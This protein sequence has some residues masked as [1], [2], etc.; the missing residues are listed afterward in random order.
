MKNKILIGWLASLLLLFSCDEKNPEVVPIF[1]TSQLEAPPLSYT[2]FNAEIDEVQENQIIDLIEDHGFVWSTSP[3]NSLD[4]P[5]S[6]IIRIGVKKPNYAFSS[7]VKN[8]IGNTTYYV[9]AFIQMNNQVYYANEISFTTKPGTWKKL[10]DFPGDPLVNATGF[11]INGK[12][13]IVK[14]SQVWEY[15]PST[16]TWERKND[17][18]FYAPAPTSFVKG[19][20]AYV[21]CTDLWHYQAELDEWELIEHANTNKSSRVWGCDGMASFV[22][23]EKVYFAGGE[24]R[25]NQLLIEFDFETMKW[26]YPSKQHVFNRAY[27]SGFSLGSSGFIVGGDIS[28]NDDLGI[29]KY[30][31]DEQ[32]FSYWGKLVNDRGYGCDRQEMICF[33]ISDRVFIGLGY[34]EFVL[35]PGIDVKS[36][37]DF[38]EYKPD[39]GVWIP[40][41]Y[42]VFVDEN[43]D[44]NFLGRSGGVSFVIEGRAFMGLGENRSYNND[45]NRYQDFW[46]FIPN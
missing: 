33:Q 20:E 7:F 28:G 6:E 30:N 27:A 21:F 41:T 9:K 5:N 15:I 22:V 17:A 14:E 8:L 36:Q 40:Q 34:G 23:G 16:D 25:L 2:Y 35:A 3:D 19:G 43:N 45:T 44:I 10:K 26:S 31:T 42:P 18:P 37:F 1:E 11:S 24:R 29:V 46:E 12:G 39:E 32:S 38:Y 4:N 13:Y